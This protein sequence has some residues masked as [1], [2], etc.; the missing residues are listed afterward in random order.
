ME[1]KIIEST[2]LLFFVSEVEGAVAGNNGLSSASLM[3]YIGD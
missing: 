3:V 1:H 2:M